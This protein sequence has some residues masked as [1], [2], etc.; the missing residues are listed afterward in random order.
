MLRQFIAWL[1]AGKKMPD[2]LLALG[3]RRIAE[4][5]PGVRAWVQIAPQAQ[6]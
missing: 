4:C 3:L 5:E 1:E 2:E 6:G